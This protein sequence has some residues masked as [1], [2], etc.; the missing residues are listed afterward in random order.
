MLAK[1]AAKQAVGVEMSR[2]GGAVD[3]GRASD[4][5]ARANDDGHTTHQTRAWAMA[6]VSIY[7]RK[8]VILPSLTVQTWA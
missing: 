5:A 3:G 7:W 1:H 4:A 8:V 2:S 6:S